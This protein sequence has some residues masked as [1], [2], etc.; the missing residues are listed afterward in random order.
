VEKLRVGI[1]NFLNSRP[2][3]WGL[4]KDQNQELF[5]PSFH[6]PAAIARLMASGEL[7]VGLLPTIELPRIPGVR[8]LPDLCVASNGP[9]GSVLLVSHLPL[10]SIRRIAVDANSRTSAALLQILLEK[11]HGIEAE[12][13][14][15]RP[16]LDHMLASSDAALLI[17]DSALAIALD[18]YVVLDLAQEWHEWTGLPF[19]FALW[20]VRP[21][22][23]PQSLSHH[24]ADS[25][26]VGLESLADLVSQGAREL[27]LEPDK[28]RDY[29][30]QRLS[31]LLREKEVLGLEK[32]LRLARE[33]GLLGQQATVELACLS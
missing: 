1:I 15:T 22:L 21:G 2:L 3:A 25:Y 13:N 31:Y 32:F 26:R 33:A 11:K 29:L 30:T 23:D 19:V 17:G 6:S 18:R 12:Y 7:D 24:F 16:D 28:V 14:E 27:Q 8:I 4:L 5:Q 10:T 9:V 20:A